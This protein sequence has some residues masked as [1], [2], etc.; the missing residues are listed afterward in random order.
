M[1]PYEIA[2]SGED[3]YYHEG[4]LH[5]TREPGRTCILAPGDIAWQSDLDAL[6][7]IAAGKP[8]ALPVESIAA[9]YLVNRKVEEA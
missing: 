2:E 6:G 1:R 7:L 3:Y 5:L 9:K 8:A 4:A